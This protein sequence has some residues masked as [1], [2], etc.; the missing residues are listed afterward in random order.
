[1]LELARDGVKSAVGQPTATAT[2]TLVIAVVCVVVLL[3]T[4][5]AAAAERAVVAHIDSVGTRMIVTFD[6]SGEA[7]IRGDSVASVNNL[8][9]VAWA[10]GLSEAV[11]VQNAN[12][13]GTER[14]GLRSVLGD[15]PDD[16]HLVTGR[17]PRAGEAVLGVQAAER[18]GL[19]EG[20]GGVTGA[21]RTWP[22]VGVVSATGPLDRLNTMALAVPTEG[23]EARYVYTLADDVR[24][25]PALA[26]Q[27]PSVVS[28]ARASDLQVDE[29]AGALALR[30]VVAG[31]LG[32][33]SRQL[34]MLVLGVGLALVSVTIL[35]SVAQRRRDFGRR[36][37]LGASRSAIVTLVMIQT[38]VAGSA[39]A[40]LGTV[41]GVAVLSV[42]DTPPPWSFSVGVA[43]LAILVALAGAV[44]PALAAA[45]RDPVR[46][47]RVP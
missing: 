44:P 21:A 37:A 17:T 1:M 20:S 45:W 43:A 7:R 46:I 34:M 28:A 3:T 2:A 15:L 30:D 35:G 8:S 5:Q 27:L 18:L 4:G 26:D 19:R 47:L 42:R 36:R 6:P 16:V 41:V 33:S 11:D 29:P 31:E 40:V 24:D 25:V 39:G 38:G 9:S 32:R 22:I 10:F 12:L 14:V 13:A 23:V